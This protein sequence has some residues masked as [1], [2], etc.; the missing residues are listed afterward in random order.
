[1]MQRQ[2]Y[3][4]AT[5]FDGTL[6]ATFEDSPSGMNVT[7]ASDRAVTEIFGVAGVNKYRELG[8]MQNREPGEL[9]RLILEGTGGDEQ[10]CK[11]FTRDYIE[12]KL[13]HLL[14]EINPKWPQLY[15]GVEEFFR[16]VEEGVLPIEIGIVSSGHD[17]FIKRVFEVHNL[18]CP[19]ILVTSDILRSRTM[20][21]RERYKPHT[22]Q[23]AEAHRQ[24]NGQVYDESFDPSSYGDSYIGR[25]HGKDHMAYAGDDPIKDGG[26]A[27]EARVP[28]LFVPF[29]KPYFSPDNGDG[30]LL[31]PDFTF[32][33]EIL[34]MQLADL[35]E[36]KSF[37]EIFLG[38]G[39][40]EVFPPVLEGARPYARML[41]GMR[42]GARE[43]LV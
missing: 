3:F 4:I 5:D 26:L 37:S 34:A 17:E 27:R 38:R 31:V 15:P 30:Q 21:R 9:V 24:W 11:N 19:D 22:Y 14:P 12:A 8:G 41:E 7:K 35:K 6:A 39:D 42:S 25:S 32:L 13:S 20:P 1:M 43:R 36:G 40:S 23:L 33:T 10:D 28:F 18:T 29:T 16:T 2:N